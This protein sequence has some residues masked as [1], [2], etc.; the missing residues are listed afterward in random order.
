MVSTPKEEGLTLGS[1]TGRRCPRGLKAFSK[2]Y[3]RLNQ[4][5]THRNGC[6]MLLLLSLLVVIEGDARCRLLMPITHELYSAVRWYLAFN[7]DV[8]DNRAI[9]IK[10][11]GEQA[12]AISRYW[13]E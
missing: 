10:G 12:Q 11:D 6:I 3:L 13:S 9:I 1:S 2:L 8:E 7:K 5:C 4:N